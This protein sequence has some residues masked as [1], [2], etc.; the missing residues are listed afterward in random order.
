MLKNVAGL[1]TLLLAEKASLSEKNP[2]VLR[3]KYGE[4]STIVFDYWPAIM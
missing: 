1:L 2:E 3:K 4:V